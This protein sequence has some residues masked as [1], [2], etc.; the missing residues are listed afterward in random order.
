[1]TFKYRYDG[2]T[3]SFPLDVEEIATYNGYYGWY[4]EAV[5]LDFEPDYGYGAIAF[6]WENKSFYY[7][8]DEIATPTWVKGPGV[9]KLDTTIDDVVEDA[10]PT[11]EQLKINEILEALRNSG[12]IAT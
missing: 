10:T 9:V 2:G 3:Y 11:P 12:L 4:D 6:I 1:M 5:E 8:D 7:Y